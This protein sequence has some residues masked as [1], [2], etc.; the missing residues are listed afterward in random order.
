VG[1]IKT[2]ILCQIHNPIY[3]AIIEII[4]KIW[5]LP[6]KL[7]EQLMVRNIIVHNTDAICMLAN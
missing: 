1:K 5:N 2:H 7:K 6:G 3:D 4:T